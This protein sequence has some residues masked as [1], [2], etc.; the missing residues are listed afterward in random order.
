MSNEPG[1]WEQPC[2]KCGFHRRWICSNDVAGC[3]RRQLEQQL[4]AARAEAKRESLAAAI[5]DQ[6]VP[7][8]KRILDLTAE[9]DALK[10]ERD[11][12]VADNAAMIGY[13]NEARA[14]LERKPRELANEITCHGLLIAASTKNHPGTALLERLAAA[15]RERDIFKGWLADIGKLCDTDRIDD[16]PRR[17]EERL[18]A[19]RLAL[20]A[21]IAAEACGTCGGTR[22]VIE[23]G[24]GPCP[25][26][27][28]EKGGDV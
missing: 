11:A 9:R 4:A 13:I 15:E 27:A 21:Q 23:C 10:R 26:C 14:Y 5:K 24:R 3:E 16:V 8:S 17:M 20:D 1:Y 18:A 22:I 25:D 28:A 6:E 19:A 7:M 2:E 12:A